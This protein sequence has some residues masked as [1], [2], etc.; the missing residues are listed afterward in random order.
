MQSLTRRAILTGLA[1]GAAT[2]LWAQLS[3]SPVPRPRPDTLGTLDVDRTAEQMIARAGLGGMI[4]FAVAD[5][6]TGAML[7]QHGA[8]EPMAPASTAKALTTAYALDSLGPA[9]RFSTRL[10]ATGPLRQGRIEGDLIL[11]GGADP[12]LSTDGLLALL[13][14]LASIGVREVAGGFYLWDGAL[15]YVGEIDPGQ[16]DHLGYNPAVS[17]LNLNYNRVHFQ[18]R[19]GQGGYAMTLDAR[20]NSVRPPVHMV[21]MS[22][23]NRAAPIYDVAL[24]A[25]TGKEVW[26]VA[27]PALGDA[28]SRWLPVRGTA[29]YAGEVFRTLAAQQSPRLTLSAPQVLTTPPIG[30]PVAEVLSEPLTDV[31]RDMLKYSNNLTAEVLGMS[32]TTARLG[33]RPEGLIESADHMTRWL[34]GLG[35]TRASLVDHSGLGPASRVTAQDMVTFLTRT[36]I[37]GP[38]WSLLKPITLQ[39]PAG[40]PEP[41][42]LRA[43]TGTLN[44]VSCL[45]GYVRRPRG[46]PRIFAILTAEPRRRA[47][48]APGDE[49]RPAGAIGWSRRSRALQYDLVRLWARHT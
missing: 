3:A 48:I 46:A 45:T 14:Q 40:A 18:W 26:T 16:P 28:G 22:T 23:A 49:E 5:G 32:A 31:A 13:A 8:L 35:L 25:A 43:K 44:F 20:T 42:E 6:D 36:G 19:R 33:R 12:G 38:L 17:G 39:T 11:A 41:F 10:L 37:E 29:R 24:D 27:R 4:G 2:P 1:A 7:H 9:H 21:T 34:H 47:A 15:P 30:V